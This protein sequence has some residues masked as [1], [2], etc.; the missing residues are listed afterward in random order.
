MK[1]SF[2]A[3]RLPK[4]GT[5]VVFASEGRKLSPT[6]KALDKTSGGALSR[7]MESSRFTGRELETLAVLAPAKLGVASVLLI[8][9]RQVG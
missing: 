9:I 2:A 5:I 6:G 1:I 7:A 8:G 3:P 4:S